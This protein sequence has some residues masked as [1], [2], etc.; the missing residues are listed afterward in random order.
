M[1]TSFRRANQNAPLVTSGAENSESGSLSALNLNMDSKAISKAAGLKPWI[2]G[3]SIV[4]TGNRQ[5]DDLIGGGLGLGTVLFIEDDVISNYGESL[6]MYGMGQAF[7]SGHK[8][9]LIT[10]ATIDSLGLCSLLPFN[11]KV[12]KANDDPNELNEFIDI[13]G[14]K[15]NNMQNEEGD[16]LINCCI[17]NELSIVNSFYSY[18]ENGGID[19]VNLMNTTIP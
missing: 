8:V 12:G 17:L 18:E 10:D 15:F 1:K 2:N 7:G 6:L 3:G 16:F 11:A 19:R 14:S 13:I 4:S 9:I 5:L